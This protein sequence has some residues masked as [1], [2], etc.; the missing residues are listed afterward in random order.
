MIPKI[1]VN[2]SHMAHVLVVPLPG[3][4]HI[5]PMLQFAKKLVSKGVAATLV[6]TRFIARTTRIDAG[7]VQ[8]E[9]I[10]D[11]HDEG[12]FS[13]AAS[14]EEYMRKLEVTG[15]ASLAELIK[16]RALSGRPFT[17]VVY[18]SFMPWAARV[19]HATDLPAVPFSTQSCTVSAVYHYVNVGRLPVPAAEGEKS[20]ALAGL[21]AME[22]WEFPTF[23]FSDGPH[24]SLTVPA[25]TQFADR[26]EDDWVLF[27]SFEELEGEVNQELENFIF[28]QVTTCNSKLKK[29]VSAYGRV[30]FLSGVGSYLAFLKF[31]DE[32]EN[33]ILFYV[34]KQIVC[35]FSTFLQENL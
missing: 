19:A 18:D 34:I 27:N 16:A 30:S 14:P 7:E 15:S 31:L 33:N 20:T 8:V 21:P 25:L 12:V 11:G 6:T 23:L 28:F 17:C 9:A 35:K 5:N 22:R 4:G 2:R 29:K 3:Q 24:P 1:F 32:T 26:D 13:S 10:S